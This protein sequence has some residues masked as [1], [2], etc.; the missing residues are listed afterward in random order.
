MASDNFL[1]A[2]KGLG[3]SKMS[4]PFQ[5][6][7]QILLQMGFPKHRAEKALA[8]TG[9][10][11]AQL[12]T[13]WLLSHVND[14]YLDDSYPREYILYAC[15]KGPFLDE[16]KEFW[17]KSLFFHGWNGAHNF[18]PHI[19]LVSFFKTPDEDAPHLAQS[20]ESVMEKDGAVLNEPLKLETYTSPNFMGFF[21][22]EEHADYL[23]RIAMQ[24]VKEVSNAIISD[25]YEHFDA[26]TACFPWCTTTTARCIPRG[27][28]SIS[29][30]PHVKS[31]H[32]TLAYQ[33]PSNHYIGLKSLVDELDSSASGEWDLHLFS[34]DPRVNGRQVYKVLREYIPTESDDLELK[35]DDYLYVSTEALNSATDCWLEG[36]SWSTGCS[37]FFPATY[38]QRVPESEAWTLHKRIP[39][40]RCARPEMSDDIG[41]N[42]NLGEEQLKEFMKDKFLTDLKDVD[43]TAS[44]SGSQESNFRRI[45]IMRHGER[46]D[47]VFG[48]WIPYCFD[49]AGNYIRK[50]LNMPVSIP[51]RQSGPEGFLHD[52]PLTTLGI[53]QARLAGECLKMKDINI[54]HVY[55]SPSFRCLQTCDAFLQGLGKKDDIKIRIEPCLFEWLAW[56]PQTLPD[57]MSQEELLAAGFN[58]DTSYT[59]FMTEK[60]L[61][62]STESCEDYYSRSAAFTKKVIASE[63]NG[64]IL[65]IGHA[66]TLDTCSRDLIHGTA[67]NADEL[68]K[69]VQKVPYCSLMEMSF[70]GK[71][72]KYLEPPCPPMTHCQN[73]RFDWK[74]LLAD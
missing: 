51:T 40:N 39:L 2:R 36:T 71:S 56:Y 33:F 74:I 16:L 29:L 27:S 48:S 22:A 72:W 30:E 60:E 43:S 55:C 20:L 73:N 67:R 17:D 31:L 59:P 15:P 18:T 8:A 69:V 42:H 23:K 64:N 46:V 9:N 34:R 7:L 65:M 21:V 41:D 11:N 4:K 24:F 13:N 5:T 50:D 12:A 63:P 66:S 58:V 47:F 6:P 49:E 38:T 1:P 61:K 35:I 57:W 37:G 32:L 62:D 45:I 68:F 14:P 28:R 52:S 70:D 10:E 53:Y 44:N 19:T 26:L 54:D 25:T 3:G